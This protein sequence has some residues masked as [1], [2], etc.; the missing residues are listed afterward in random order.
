MRIFWYLLLEQDM[1]SEGERDD[2]EEEHDE[3]P[4]KS[5]ENVGE[6][7]DV[8]SEVGKFLDE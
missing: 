2:E 4:R 6:H 5:R 3:K 7:D 8:Y 1:K